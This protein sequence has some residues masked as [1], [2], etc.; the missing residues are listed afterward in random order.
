M[1]P[2]RVLVT[3]GGSPGFMGTFKSLVHNYDNRE[4]YIVAIDMKDDVIGKHYAKKFYKIPK[5]TEDD[6]LNSIKEIYKKEA[7]DVILPQNTVELYKLAGSDMN[8]AVSDKD[9]VET[10]NDK[11]CIISD[12]S[13]YITNNIKELGYLAYRELG[14]PKKR[15]V[16]KPPKS[17]G[18]RGMR[19][20]DDSLDYKDMFFNEKLNSYISMKQLKSILGREFEPLM[21]MEYLEGDE[22]TVDCYRDD[23]Q[24]IAIPRRRDEIKNGVSYRTTTVEDKDLIDKSKKLAE[25]LDLKYAFGFQF[26]DGKVIECNPRVQGTMIASTFA[27]ANIIYSAVKNAF[28]EEVPELKAEWGVKLIRYE[29]FKPYV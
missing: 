22:Y 10:A 27:G 15:I 20:I 1:L 2:I 11:A 29:G 21:V 28:G 9:S 17:N 14:Y 19:I 16:V 24:F 3:G 4:V 13:W 23:N 25:E 7:I 18:S 26:I 12:S 8:V 6:Y 5:A